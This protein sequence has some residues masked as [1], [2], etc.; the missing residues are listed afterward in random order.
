MPARS[1][2]APFLGLARRPSIALSI[3]PQGSRTRRTFKSGATLAAWAA[4]SM[5][6]LLRTTRRVMYV[7][8]CWDVGGALH[9]GVVLNATGAGHGPGILADVLSHGS[10]LICRLWAAS[11]STNP[12]R[13]T[14]RRVL[15]AG[16]HLP[17]HSR[18]ISLAVWARSTRRTSPPARSTPSLAADQIAAIGAGLRAVVKFVR[19]PD[20]VS[21]RGI[22]HLFGRA[23]TAE[24]DGARDPLRVLPRRGV[25][26]TLTVLAAPSDLIYAPLGAV[27]PVG[28]SLPAGRDP[29]RILIAISSRP[30]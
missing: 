19:L 30:P 12:L 22:G 14:P 20:P 27:I 23:T 6:Q 3:C 4:N 8:C 10:F 15:A 17:F 16:C 9:P 25:I 29:S 5:N 26:G 2:D 11:S 1:H 24:H 13:S 18:T 28:C 7:L 21:R